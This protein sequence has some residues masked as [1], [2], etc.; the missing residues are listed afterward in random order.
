MDSVSVMVAMGP[1]VY[2]KYL[3]SPVLVSFSQQANVGA[4]TGSQGLLPDAVSYAV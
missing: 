3:L 1:V 2:A 4:R